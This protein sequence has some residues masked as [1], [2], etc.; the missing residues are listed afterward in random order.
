[1]ECIPPYTPV[2]YSKTGVYR[3]ISISSIFDP[4]H[5]LWVLVRITLPRQ[6][7]S[8]PTINVLLKILNISNFSNKIF[9][10]YK[11]KKNL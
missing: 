6:F 9:N 3:G 7:F 10:L 1:M 11:N 8:I 2:L 4:K 5:R